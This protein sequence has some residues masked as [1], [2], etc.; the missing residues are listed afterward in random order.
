MRDHLKAVQDEIHKEAKGVDPGALSGADAALTDSK[1]ELSKLEDSISKL[2]SELTSFDEQNA[3][4]EARVEKSQALRAKLGQLQTAKNGISL[5]NEELEKNEKEL[6]EWTATSA[7]LVFASGAIADL[8]A[9]IEKSK[10]TGTFPPDF[11]A[12]AIQRLLDDGDCICGRDLSDAHA[13]KH[14]KDLLQQFE[15]AGPRGTE[16]QK[17]DR[18][19]AL[20]RERQSVNSRRF[21]ELQKVRIAVTKDLDSLKADYDRLTS[22]V[23]D[24]QTV[25]EIEVWEELTTLLNLRKEKDVELALLHKDRENKEKEVEEA[26]ISYKKLA[27][28]SSA[29]SI[30]ATEYEFLEA[31]I[32]SVQN[33]YE[34][35]L[36]RVRE[37]LGAEIAKNYEEWH[38]KEGSTDTILLDEDFSIKK[39]N[40][41]GHQEPFSMGEYRLLYYSLCLALRSV[42]GFTFPLII[43]SPWGNMD[44]KSRA[45]LA[46]AVTKA[47]SNVQTAVFV[48]DSEYPPEIEEICRKGAPRFFNL[49]MFDD[50]NSAAKR[51]AFEA[52]GG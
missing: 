12:S 6:A 2:D 5:L 21:K 22:E 45:N 18:E 8:E 16:L 49:E 26:E 23:G 38:S 1:S 35:I 14:V 13:K 43:D 20:F 25:E 4:L 29:A 46:E 11:Q 27:G 41:S 17:L 32:L 48:L 36:I 24:G 28:K 39:F 50:P 31:A 52:I 9:A 51:S 42:S 37:L 33:V 40:K 15:G 47:S 3:D 44:D 34:T 30:L 19:V 7:P 10:A